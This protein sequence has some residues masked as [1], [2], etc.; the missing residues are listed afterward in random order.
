MTTVVITGAASGMGAALRA[1]LEAE[2]TTVIGVDLPGSGA[3]VEADLATVDGRTLMADG[4]AERSG[5]TIDG[6]VAGA[7]MQSMDGALAGRTVRT[8]YFGAVATLERLRPLLARGTDASAV[9]ISSNS[10]TTQPGYPAE[11]ADVLLAGDEEAAVA[12]VGEDAIS[13]YPIS[14][15]ALGRWV[16]RHATTD[17]W[18]GNGIRLNAIAPGFVDTAMTA[19]TWEFVSSLGDTYPIPIGRPGRVEEMAALLAFLLSPEAGFFV[20]SFLTADGG[21][22]ARV[23]ADDWPGPR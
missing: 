2:G 21:T 17:E 12:A 10:T 4:V 14:K 19:G 1:R 7:G 8:N 13:A 20:G 11:L 22:E 15:L 3:T 9:A 6:L 5:G 16:R 18:I 23:R